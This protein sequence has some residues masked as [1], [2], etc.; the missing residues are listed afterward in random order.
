MYFP[1]SAQIYLDQFT[2]LVEL[3]M[4]NPQTYLR[5]Y[6]PGFSVYR[7]FFGGARTRSALH[8]SDE[9]YSIFN[10][11]YFFLC[12]PFLAVIAACLLR[13]IQLFLVCVKPRQR[14]KT[15]L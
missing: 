7:H 9:L 4:F 13:I 3:D 15:I 1:A 10:D 6:I 8:H 2:R 12:I 5:W 11:W 14:V